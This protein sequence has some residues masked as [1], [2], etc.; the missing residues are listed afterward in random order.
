MQ[1]SALEYQ[2]SSLRSNPETAQSKG[3]E[4]K[5]TVESKDCPDPTAQSTPEDPQSEEGAAQ[6]RPSELLF[7]P[8]EAL[9]I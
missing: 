4:E 9:Q 6:V 7:G 1:P 5:A 2:Q 8:L 3:Q